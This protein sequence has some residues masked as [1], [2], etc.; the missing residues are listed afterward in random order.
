MFKD[1]G[2]KTFV[3]IG[4]CTIVPI[5]SKTLDLQWTTFSNEK[6]H[7]FFFFFNILSKRVHGDF[8][9]TGSCYKMLDENETDMQIIYQEFN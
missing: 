5:F 9:P 1:P 6:E 4:H 3:P 8:N 7:I 2:W